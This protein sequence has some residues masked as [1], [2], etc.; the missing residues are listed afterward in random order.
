MFES[1]TVKNLKWSLAVS[2]YYGRSFSKHKF[3]KLNNIQKDLYHRELPVTYYDNDEAKNKK[4]EA[5]IPFFDL[6]GH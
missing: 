5:H 1:L 2:S 4:G 3:F 6:F